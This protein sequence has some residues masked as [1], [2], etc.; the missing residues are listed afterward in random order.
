[1]KLSEVDQGEFLGE[2]GNIEFESKQAARKWAEDLYID[3]GVMRTNLIAR[4]AHNDADIAL[5]QLLHY[6]RNRLNS[7]IRRIIRL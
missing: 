5:I 7:L 6:R 3:F 1:M 2:H 4:H